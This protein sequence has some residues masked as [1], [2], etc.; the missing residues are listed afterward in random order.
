MSDNTNSATAGND[1]YYLEDRERWESL[2]L[3]WQGWNA[4]IEKI[5]RQ[6]AAASNAGQQ[7]NS[8]ESVPG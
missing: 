3:D 5:L 8:E 2:G 7:E 4:T 6:R 1:K